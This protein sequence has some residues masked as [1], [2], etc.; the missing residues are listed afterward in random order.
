MACPC[1]PRIQLPGKTESW[2]NGPFDALMP[3]KARVKFD[4]PRRHIIKSKMPA[5]EPAYNILP[6]RSM[7]GQLPLEQHIGVRIPGGQ[8]SVQVGYSAAAPPPIVTVELPNTPLYS[9]PAKAN[10]CLQHFPGIS[11]RFARR[12]V[13]DGRHVWVIEAIPSTTFHPTEPT[14]AFYPKSGA[15][16][17]LISRTIPG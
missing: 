9:G 17:G 5:D 11:K 15:R 7:V 8:P 2:K 6:P 16:Y 12:G 13:V 10:S 4:L 14:P 1:P 3:G